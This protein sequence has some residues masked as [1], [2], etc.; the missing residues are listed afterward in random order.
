MI[1]EY[2]EWIRSIQRRLM[3]ENQCATSYIFWEAAG[4][5]YN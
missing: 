3:L 2:L 4:G 1:D 5:K